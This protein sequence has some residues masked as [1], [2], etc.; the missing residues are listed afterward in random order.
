[1]SA[2]LS[3]RLAD[4]VREE[5]EAQAEALGIGLSTLLRDLATAAA[6]EARRARIRAASEAVG[7][8]VAGF[9]EAKAFYADWGAPGLDA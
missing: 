3:I 4:D 9:A 1:M 2:P 6:R 5:L 8:H 7:T